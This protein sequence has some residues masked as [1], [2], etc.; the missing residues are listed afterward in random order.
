MAKILVVDDSETIRSMV[1]VEL[2]KAGYEVRTAADGK[3]ALDDIGQHLPELIVLD[4]EMPEM[5]GYSLLRNI[6]KDDSPAKNVP[7][8]MLTSKGKYGDMFFMEGA[9]DFIEKSPEAI[10]DL[11]GKV[12]S[13]M[14]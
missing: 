10:Q 6:R 1:A 2:S 11:V 4:V 7:V 8:L 3:E 14:K 5:D 13:L 9:N 12:E